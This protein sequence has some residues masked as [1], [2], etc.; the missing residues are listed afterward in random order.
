VSANNSDV[1]GAAPPSLRAFG[2]AA[3]LPA[4]SAGRTICASLK[5]STAPVAGSASCVWVPA[6][7]GPSAG[8]PGGGGPDAGRRTRE[9]DVSRGAVETREALAHRAAAG[10]QGFDGAGELACLPTK[11]TDVVPGNRSWW[12]RQDGRRSARQICWSARS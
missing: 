7:D 12:C 11:W 5:V 3:V 9:A 2:S 6:Q 4:E 8:G 1:K 10:P